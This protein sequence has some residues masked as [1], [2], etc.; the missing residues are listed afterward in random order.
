MAN[1]QDEAT[2]HGEGRLA[3]QLLIGYQSFDDLTNT[4]TRGQFTRFDEAPKNIQDDVDAERTR[5]IAEFENL[6]DADARQQVL[7]NL[8]RLEGPGA[9]LPER[10]A[11]WNRRFGMGM[12]EGQ[13]MAPDP[14]FGR[15]VWTGLKTTSEPIQFASDPV[16]YV[17]DIAGLAKSAAT[18]T[19]DPEALAAHDANRAAR[20]E[21]ERTTLPGSGSLPP[22]GGYPSELT[23]QLTRM[24]GAIGEAVSQ[25]WGAVREKN[26]EQFSRS[27]KWLASQFGDSSAGVALDILSGLNREHL[28][29]AVGAVGGLATT[30][31]TPYGIKAMATRAPGRVNQLLDGL[32]AYWRR[33]RPMPGGDV[34]PARQ[35]RERDAFVRGLDEPG[36]GITVQDVTGE[37]STADKVVGFTTGGRLPGYVRG[38]QLI[39]NLKARFETSRLRARSG[40]SISRGEGG[41]LALTQ[42][43]QGT[44]ELFDESQRLYQGVARQ[45]DNAMNADMTDMR[46]WV[47]KERDLLVKKPGVVLNPDQKEFAQW[48]DNFLDQTSPERIQ[49]YGRPTLDDLPAESLAD[50]TRE[51]LKDLVQTRS[52]RVVPGGRG[53]HG[54]VEAVD[55][56]A[57]KAARE[58]LEN[59]PLM[60]VER[61]RSDVLAAARRMRHT[62]PD[63]AARW[64]RV[65][66]QFDDKMK[67]QLDPADYKELEKARSTYKEVLARDDRVS[68]WNKKRNLWEKERAANRDLAGVTDT[69]FVFRHLTAG[70][71]KNIEVLKAFLKDAPESTPILRR[72]W[73]DDIAGSGLEPNTQELL[74]ATKKWNDLGPETKKLLFGDDAAY[75]RNLE[76]FFILTR[77]TM[78]PRPGSKKLLDSRSA[79]YETLAEVGA[80]TTVALQAGAGPALATALSMLTAPA[81]AAWAMGSKT[82]ARLYMGLI[83]MPITTGTKAARATL[84][85]E[86]AG[87]FGRAHAAG[88]VIGAPGAPTDPAPTP[89]DPHPGTEMS[90]SGLVQR[91]R[92]EAERK[93]LAA[94]A[95]LNNPTGAM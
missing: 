52:P 94:E 24:P 82:T 67:A 34:D 35:A 43:R 85:T 47:Q 2:L 73:L 79:M 37:A 68:Q 41:R 76:D 54:V 48:A 49:F 90:W 51:E 70:Q 56:S 4:M 12:I 83:K 3:R 32:S 66:A 58:A 92:D 71:D 91:R 69:D 63:L 39:D 7:L 95:A 45:A 20:A 55:V 11:D 59:T 18:P 33:K 86:L 26:P 46:K 78:D 38:R 10:A 17:S 81:F 75:L 74:K 27:R 8:Q 77:R 1:P 23:T 50:Y 80:V 64:Q 62:N 30:G 44:R 29:M 13:G 36:P 16:G 40:E 9:K 6:S 72:A 42:H 15:G 93:K 21:V 65:G 88:Q 61:M 57:N 89:G 25:G 60:Q 53:A 84:A 19:T 87:A 28:G 22:A 31:A 5:R 14:S